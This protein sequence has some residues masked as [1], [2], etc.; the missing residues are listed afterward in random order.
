MAQRTDMSAAKTETDI[1]LNKAN[2]ALARSQRLV[3]SWLP[4]KTSEEQAIVNSESQRED[5]IFVAVPETL[6]VGAPLPS[7]T[8]DGSWNRTELDNNDQ[9]RKHLLGRNYKAVVAEGNPPANR[10]DSK[11]RSS[12][13]TTLTTNQFQTAASRTVEDESDDEDG[14][15]ALVGKKKQ[16]GKRKPESGCLA[17]EPLGHGQDADKAKDG[18][19]ECGDGVGEGLVRQGASFSQSTLGPKRKKKAPSFLD[20]ILADRSKR[21]K[22]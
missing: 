18:N 16:P 7:K 21:K 6:G 5:E 9:L 11:V 17:L 3:A 19:G 12:L 8:A 2:V 22:R 14:R 13:S 4:P 10:R 1:I 15:T 20:E